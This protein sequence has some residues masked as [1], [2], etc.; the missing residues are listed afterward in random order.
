[1]KPDKDDEDMK[2]A[3]LMYGHWGRFIC[4]LSGRFDPEKYFHA[5][6]IQICEM[7]C[8]CWIVA[9][10]NNR[11]GLI[12]KKTPEATIADIPKSLL[13]TARFGEWDSEMMDW[14]NPC[15]KSFRDVMRKRGKNTP[16]AKKSIYGLIERYGEG[17]VFAS[18]HS[19][20]N[21][22]AISAT[23][24]TAKEAKRRLEEKIKIML[25]RESV[26]LVLTPITPL[27]AH[28]CSVLRPVEN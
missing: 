17:K 6:P 16:H 28:R 15:P 7:K 5:P 4:H 2:L 24:R 18:T 20:K 27:E 21:R 13:A 1:M 10:G 14:W 26:T 22:A 12:L 23:G 8:G 25:K 11:V 19:V 9:D 3:D